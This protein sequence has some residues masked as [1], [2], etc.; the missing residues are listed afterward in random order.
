MHSAHPSFMTTHRI[1]VEKALSH[2]TYKIKKQIIK[3]EMQIERI[4]SGT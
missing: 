1:Q 2:F 4:W 3:L